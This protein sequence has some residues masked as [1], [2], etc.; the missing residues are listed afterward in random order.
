MLYF[1][2]LVS[3]FMGISIFVDILMQ[4]PSLLKNS[5]DIIYPHNRRDKQV[6]TFLKDISLKGNM[7]AQVKF[8]LTTLR[9]LFSILAIMQWELLL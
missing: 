9:P 7:M 1:F 4:K 3:L 6:L 2:G 5:T 8:E